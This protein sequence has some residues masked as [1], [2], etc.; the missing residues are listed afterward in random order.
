MLR[1]VVGYFAGAPKRVLRER[2]IIRGH[3][4]EALIDFG[5][6]SQ[7]RPQSKIRLAHNGCVNRTAWNACPPPRAHRVILC[8]RS[9]RV[10]SS[11]PLEAMQRS[12]VAVKRSHAMA[13][14]PPCV[15]NSSRPARLPERLNVDCDLQVSRSETEPRAS[16]PGRDPNVTNVSAARKQLL[17][18]A[19]NDL[20]S[21]PLRQSEQPTQ[22]TEYPSDT[23]RVIGA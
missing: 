16:N 21:P 2:P 7:I 18:A 9:D 4:C 15:A 12:D 3:K 23:R 11:M 5:P 19:I 8:F 6:V 1:D 20:V 17:S 10:A 13:D 22:R 14:L